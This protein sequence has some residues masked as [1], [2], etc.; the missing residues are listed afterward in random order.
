MKNFKKYKSVL[1]EIDY[2]I[3]ALCEVVGENRL[4]FYIGKGKGERCLQHLSPSE[5]D[6]KG[7]KIQKL[8]SENRLGIDILRHGIKTD[9]EAKLVEATCI[10]LLG[11]GNLTNKVR[12]SGVEMGKVSIEEIYS[13]RS[14]KTINIKP[15][16][17]GV[18]FLLNSTYKSG[19][20]ELALFEATRGIWRNIRRGEDIKFAYATNGGLIKEVYE[21]HD[22]APAGTQQYF[23]RSF[24]AEDLIGRWEFIGKK[25]SD[26][27]REK[28]IGKILK[29]ERSFGSPFVYVGLKS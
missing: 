7:S 3:Y 14:G 21:I 10:D 24:E 28:Y 12:G 25:A 16:H 26:E 4:P 18:A 29:K 1:E 20:S 11:V 22:W 15:H 27:V 19:M 17:A 23:E 6:E 2:Y 5:E 9:K 13:L 8:T